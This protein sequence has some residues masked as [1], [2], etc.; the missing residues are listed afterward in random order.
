MPKRK[1]AE[2]AEDVDVDAKVETSK[3]RRNKPKSDEVDE[4]SKA[5]VTDEKK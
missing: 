3:R 5:E 2:I 4:D 1:A